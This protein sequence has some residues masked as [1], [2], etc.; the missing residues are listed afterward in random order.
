MIQRRNGTKPE[1]VFVGGEFAELREKNNLYQ[2]DLERLE[3]WAILAR[4]SWYKCQILC[5]CS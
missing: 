3:Q 5:L 1:V 4:L 2:K